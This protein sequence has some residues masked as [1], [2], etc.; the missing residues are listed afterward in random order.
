MPPLH[1]L[2]ASR[3]KQY[4]IIYLEAK[5]LLLPVFLRDLFTRTEFQFENV[6]VCRWRVQKFAECMNAHLLATSNDA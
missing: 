4:V 6:A 3:Y 5:Q 1:S 2:T